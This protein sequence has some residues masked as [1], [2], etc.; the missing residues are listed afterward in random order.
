MKPTLQQLLSEE[1]DSRLNDL[2]AFKTP[3]CAP[4]TYEVVRKELEEPEM[5][6]ELSISVCDLRLI[7]DGLCFADSVQDLGKFG[8]RA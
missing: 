4:K 3:K 1:V 6:L 7:S 8:G 5:I 2:C